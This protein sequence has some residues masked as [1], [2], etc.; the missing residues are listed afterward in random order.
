MKSDFQSQS[1]R[2]PPTFSFSLFPFSFPSSKL[3]CYEW[4]WFVVYAVYKKTE[5]EAKIR[6]FSILAVPQKEDSAA[7]LQWQIDCL[8]LAY[9]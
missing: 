1:I 3:K 6:L 9:L 2:A 8:H 5:K 4:S 7:D